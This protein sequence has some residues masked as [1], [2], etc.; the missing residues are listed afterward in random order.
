MDRKRTNRRPLGRTILMGCAVFSIFLCFIMGALGAVNY[1]RGMMT[2]YESY[3]AGILRYAMTEIDGDDL[4]RCME[5][6]QKSDQYEKTQQ[7]LD[8]IKETHEIE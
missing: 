1:Y 5:T 7:V 3:M 4:A 6:D 8:R 2:K